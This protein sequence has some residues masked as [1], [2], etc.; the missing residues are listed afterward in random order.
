MYN[1]SSTKL[2]KLNLYLKSSLMHIIFAI[3]LEKHY[4]NYSHTC[5][6]NYIFITFAIFASM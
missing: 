5:A 1:L 3:T 6:Y 4:A 2:K